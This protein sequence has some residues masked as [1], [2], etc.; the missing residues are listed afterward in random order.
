LKTRL[1][2]VGGGKVVEEQWGIFRSNWQSASAPVLFALGDF[3][4]EAAR[5]L[6]SSWPKPT[7]QKLSEFPTLMGPTSGF[8]WQLALAGRIKFGLSSFQ[9][10][11]V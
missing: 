11:K 10:D 7:A 6:A 8:R 9:T 5:C 2:V 1:S 3:P 4:V